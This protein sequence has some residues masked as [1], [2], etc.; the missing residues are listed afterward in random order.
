MCNSDGVAPSV[1]AQE[2]LQ[3]HVE[4]TPERLRIIKQALDAE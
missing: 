2:S 1:L 3:T 4:T